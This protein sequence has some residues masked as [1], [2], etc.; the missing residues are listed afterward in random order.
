MVGSTITAAGAFLLK[1]LGGLWFADFISGVVHWLED[2]YGNPEWPVIGHTIRENQQHHFTPRSFLKG[3]L[4]TRNREVLAIGAAF[5][6]AFWAFDVLNAFTVSA[7]IFG[8]MSNEAHASAHRSPPE[9]GRIITALQKT[10]LLQ[11]H[12]HHAAHHRKG[13]D[14]HFCVLTNHVNPVLERIRFF[15]T[16]EAIVTRVTGV[17]PR[18]DL[19]VNPRYRPAI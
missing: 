17:R 10:G 13:K 9:N 18:P 3:T 12:R 1:V 5:L 16:L 19:S 8:V 2:R 4:W 7:V 14:T 15:Q 11:S 6:A